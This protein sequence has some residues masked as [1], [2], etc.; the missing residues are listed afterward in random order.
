VIDTTKE[1][2]SNSLLSF[3]IFILR[4]NVFFKKKVKQHRMNVS[5]ANYV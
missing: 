1:R 3:F 2:A 4:L 5:T